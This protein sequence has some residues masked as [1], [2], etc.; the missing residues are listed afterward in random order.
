M[1]SDY[2]IEFLRHIKDFF[3][4][5]FKIDYFNESD[6]RDTDDKEKNSPKVRLTCVGIGYRNTNKRIN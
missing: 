5:T 3:G 1:L 2:T 6:E 4:V